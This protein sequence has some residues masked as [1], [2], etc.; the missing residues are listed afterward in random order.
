MKRWDYKRV[1]EWEEVIV[2]GR[3]GWELINIVS[4]HQDKSIFY[5]K[6]PLPS[7]REQIT[8]EQRNNVIIQKKR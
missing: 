3:E 2:L 5:L 4:H 1:N 6:R 8:S 7:L